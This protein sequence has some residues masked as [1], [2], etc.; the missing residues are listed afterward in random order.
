MLGIDEELTTRSGEARP[1]S[2]ATFVYGASTRAGVS[3]GIVVIGVATVGLAALVDDDHDGYVLAHAMASAPF[4]V[5][6]LVCAAGA[7]RSGA[8]Q[9]RVFW[10]RWLQ[11]NTLAS[12]ATLAAIGA[13]VFESSALLVLDMVLML[14]AVPFWVSAS[15]F[16]L[17]AQAGRRDASVD[18]VDG[19]MAIIVLG[20]PGVL[21][22]AGPML[23]RTG[24][25]PPNDGRW[26]YEVK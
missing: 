5:G 19:A 2:S 24:P 9:F 22:L 18:V 14:A 21:L 15:L 25:L 3:I 16:M 26:A 7:R 6:A 11:A 1:G 8:P 17:A 20:A 12:G 13:V 4:V 23:A 10:Q